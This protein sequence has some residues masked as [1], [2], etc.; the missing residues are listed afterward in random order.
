MRPLSLS[1]EGQARQARWELHQDAFDFLLDL[2]RGEPWP[3][4]LA[5]LE[6][7]RSGDEVPQGWVPATFL[8]A[9]VDGEV[10]GRVSI[11]HHL[12]PYLSEVAGHIGICVRPDFRRRGYAKAIMGQ[13]L[14]VAAATGLTQLLVTCDAD[15]VGAISATVD[16][17]G[18]LENVAAARQ[19][20]RKFRFWV[21]TRS[22]P[23]RPRI[24]RSRRDV[25]PR[26]PSGRSGP[27]LAETAAGRADQPG[28]A[29]APPLTPQQRR[30]PTGERDSAPEQ[31]VGL[32]TLGVADVRRSRAFYERMGW[33]GHQ[34]GDTVLV[35]VGA[36]ALVLSGRDE[37]A[38]DCGLHDE[39]AGGFS[40]VV[41]S[42]LVGSAAA[43]EEVMR[44]AERAGATVT[45][46]VAPT[47]DGGCAAIF[48]DPDGHAWQV[49]G[50]G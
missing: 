4:Y 45:R 35:R 17:G 20:V 22:Q 31:Q 10:V 39:Q 6:R 50:R 29:P 27:T 3:A 19:S 5:R 26:L 43:V 48:T 23:V 8:V 15:N 33:A 9:E 49:L 2:R 13:S 7:L 1:D 41:L 12:N 21:E 28:S 11:R 44:S 36:L 38:D 30:S 34:V 40:G 14:P 32:V 46:R 18:V 37:L 42:H 47:V 16:C 24:P 25:T